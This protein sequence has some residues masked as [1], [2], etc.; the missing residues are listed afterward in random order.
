L[1]FIVFVPASAALLLL[2]L[3]LFASGIRSMH[4]SLGEPQATRAFFAFLGIVSYGFP[5]ATMKRLV[6]R[7]ALRTLEEYMILA[8]PEQSKKDVVVR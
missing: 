5:Y 8:R 7:I 6:T 2:V 1:E 3:P 4:S